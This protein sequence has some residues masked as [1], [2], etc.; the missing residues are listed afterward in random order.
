MGLSQIRLQ[1]FA[2]G[3]VF[4]SA[5]CFFFYLAHTFASKAEFLSNF[6]QGECLLAIEAEIED[7]DIRFTLSEG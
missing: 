4:E 5:R 7:D 3:A 2:S 1:C 6:F